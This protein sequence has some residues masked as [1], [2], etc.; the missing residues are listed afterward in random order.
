MDVFFI[1]K[2][3]CFFLYSTL[4][5][6]SLRG[7][8]LDMKRHPTDSMSVPIAF[9]LEKASGYRALFSGKKSQDNVE[10]AGLLYM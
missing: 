6:A 4:L 2:V 7:R 5:L 9:P 1:C 10:N 8:M 3:S